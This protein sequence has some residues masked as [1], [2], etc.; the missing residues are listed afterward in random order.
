[1]SQTDGK[2][3]CMTDD[4]AIFWHNDEHASA[5]FYDLLARSERDAFDDD[6]LARLAA[7]RE[8]APESERADIFAAQYL[9][10]HGDAENAVI[11][12]ERAYE[13]RPL[14]LEVWR[15]LAAGYKICGRELDSI[16]MQ[17]RAYGL[18]LGADMGGIDLDLS[19]TEENMN[20]ALGQLSF[21]VGK[22]LNAPI[23]TSRAY[24]MNPGLGFRFDVFI[25]EAIPITYPEDSMRFWS[26]VYIE[27]AGL[28]DHS[29]M[30]SDARHDGWLSRYGHRDFFFDLQKACEIRGTTEI[31]L[32][33]GR[34]AIVPIAGTMPD[35]K[36]SV[37]T[38][39]TGTHD[40]YL[41]KWA[42]SFF[43]LNENT[44]LHTDESTPY[45]VGSPILLGHSPARRKVVLNI[46]VDGLSG[47]IAHAHSATHL[48]NISKFFA[49]GTVFTQHF[50]TSEHTLPSFPAIETGY[51]PHHTHL[52]N[53]NAGY[54]L[55]L[56]M[57][58]TAEQMKNLGYYCAIPMGSNQGISHGIM[59]GFDRLVVSSW[60]QNSVDGV[61]YVLRQLRAFDE[62]DQYLYLA[63]NDVHP[64]DGLGYKFDTN[65]ETHLPL[66]DRFFSHTERKAS[67]FLSSMKIYQ[68]Q[69]LERIRQV[70]Q[71]I[72]LL[73]AYL[74]EHF[75]EDEYLVSIYSDHGVSIFNKVISDSLDIISPYA[76][77]ATWM[78]RGAGVPENVVS[79]ELTSIVDIYPTLAHLCDFA[80]ARDI[81]GNLPAVFGGKE[82]DAVYS[83]SQY[84][85]QTFKLAVRTHEH[86]LRLETRAPVDEDGTVDFAGARVGIYPREHELEEDYAVDSAE[87][88]AFFYPR[89]RDFIRGIANN[90]EFWPAMRAARPQWFGG[91]A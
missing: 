3:D 11:C 74:E 48:P 6:F 22:C 21:A 14:N 33:E 83:S 19:L 72:G 78:M 49:R 28:S 60:I 76:T 15:V 79:D 42:F 51:Y 71:N 58:T 67:V 7:Y 50:S 34:E 59:R 91:P 68:E 70:D 55:P 24:F 46:L 65:I 20:E 26:A 39:S 44:Q 57:T 64:Y 30:L 32:P 16:T 52:F 85:G 87:L 35:Q 12:G 89:A 88:R 40:I 84:P 90:G 66:T 56:R 86:A 43:R 63:V 54:E 2:D 31:Q 47:A 4:F 36:L 69:Y 37:T 61:D 10:H 82:R 1:M 27:N 23:I 75:D 17:G 25:G 73:L 41:G 62:V 77:S 18:Y 29:Y 53:V 80:A 5:L 13:R 45:A 81:D 9:L 38:A 8:A